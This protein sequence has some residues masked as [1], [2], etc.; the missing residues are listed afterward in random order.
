MER[1]D[2]NFYIE[3]NCDEFGSFSCRKNWL[4]REAFS[5]E[6]CI[7]MIVGAIIVFF[8]YMKVTDL[9]KRNENYS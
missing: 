5:F 2:I 3:N 9:T 1:K 6:V 4:N 8:C 7:L